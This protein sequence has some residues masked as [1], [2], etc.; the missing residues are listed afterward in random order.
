MASHCIQPMTPGTTEKTLMPQ[1][2]NV[3]IQTKDHHLVVFCLF[4]S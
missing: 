1:K 3:L 2:L 4:V